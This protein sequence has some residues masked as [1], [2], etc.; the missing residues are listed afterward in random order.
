[1]RINSFEIQNNN[2]SNNDNDNMIGSNI[3]IEVKRILENLKS[4]GS[5]CR[6][7][8]KRNRILHTTHIT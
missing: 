3:E 7:N 6:N 5:I 8:N 4:V 1:M 2:I